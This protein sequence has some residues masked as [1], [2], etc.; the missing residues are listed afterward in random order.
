MFEQQRAAYFPVE[1]PGSV[2]AR[3]V[4]YETYAPIRKAL[5]DQVFPHWNSLPRYQ[6][7]PE[8]RAKV[9]RLTKLFRKAHHERFVFYDDDTPIGWSMGH[10]DDPITFR[11]N[12]SGLLPDYRRWG[13]YTAFTRRL[14]DYLKTL[15]YERVTSYHHPTNRAVLIAKL[16]LGFNLSG[17]W[18]NEDGG[19]VVRLTYYFYEDRF[20]AFER[21]FGMEPDFTRDDSV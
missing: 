4:D 19:A 17:H 8:R 2:V 7:P 12:N 16:R 5:F 21:A 3:P 13:I 14:L 1:L 11:M 10:M 18:L 15:G 6:L 20:Q 9:A